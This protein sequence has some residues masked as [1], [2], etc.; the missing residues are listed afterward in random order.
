MKSNNVF[1]GWLTPLLVCVVTLICFILLVPENVTA[2]YWINMVWIIA[3][4][5]LF[6]GWMHIGYKND[7]TQTSQFHVF[8]GTATI[9]YILC[10]VAWMVAYWKL[11][12]H[13]SL[14]AYI[15]GILVITVLWIVIASITGKHD[16]AYHEQQ[17]ALENN[18]LDVRTFAQQIKNLAEEHQTEETKRAWAA[19]IR[20]AES[21]VPSQIHQ[22]KDLLMAKAEK[23]I[24]A[25]K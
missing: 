9:Y 13:I 6:F 5:G 2:A 3:L 19:L 10:S 1:Y 8:L 7:D 15:V 18:T 17:T 20:E 16:S 22:Q 11:G 12:D 23:I 21:V 14:N 25:N 4:E 24:N